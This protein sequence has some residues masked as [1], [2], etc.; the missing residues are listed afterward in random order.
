[1]GG[2]LIL[3]NYGFVIVLINCLDLCLEDFDLVSYLRDFATHVRYEYDN[4]TT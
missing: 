4:I 3:F 2:L 1:M